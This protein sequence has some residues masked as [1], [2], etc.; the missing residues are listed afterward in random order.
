MSTVLFVCRHNAGRPQMSRALFAQAADSRH[1][2]PLTIDS[3]L[4]ILDV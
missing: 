4:A 3:F 2:Y 1:Q